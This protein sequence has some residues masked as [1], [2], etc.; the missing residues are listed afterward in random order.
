MG[1]TMKRIHSMGCAAALIANRFLIVIRCSISP[2][3]GF[4]LILLAS[5]ATTPAAS[6]QFQYTPEHPDVEIMVTNA[7]SYMNSTRSQKIGESTLKS[8]AIVQA[9]KRYFQEV[10]RDN[11]V[12]NATIGRILAMFPDE[13][14]D[15]DDSRP[16][17]TAITILNQDEVYFPSLAT[18]L[19]AEFDKVKY[20]EEIKRL[21]KALQDRQRPNGAFTY[22]K[23]P[24]T[25]DTSQT[26]YVAL[27]LMVAKHH[28]FRIDVNVADRALEWLVA[29]Q[30]PGGYWEYK[31]FVSDPNS[32]GTSSNLPATHSIHAAA[33]GTAY[34]T[35]DVLQLS[36]RKK[37][38]S[39]A[40]TIDSQKLPS[41]VMVYTKPFDGEEEDAPTVGPLVNFD[42][43][44]LSN[45]YR[46][47]NKWLEDN[48][49]VAPPR[50][51]YYYLYALERYAWFRE[52]SEGD[53]GDGALRE[54]YDDGVN[55]LLASQ[56]ENGRFRN[57]S[58]WVDLGSSRI[59]SC[60]PRTARFKPR[61]PNEAWRT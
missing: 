38:M 51:K 18:I 58:F 24:N 56:E 10:P 17:G 36:K 4:A 61:K 27:A 31:L 49:T 30:R 16:G 55:D 8:L 47:G 12:V 7:V 57:K 26:Q 53:V 1:Q 44:R 35:A 3:L 59:P 9:H 29:S 28:G 39:K 6:A 14:A 52:Q 32:P 2:R 42:M 33:L 22:L 19:L 13:T 40:V 15:E 20:K 48:F 11:A 37:S 54:W 41:T 25:A 50:W 60:D 21:L 5:L 45:S 46:A 34:L 43:G 23:Q